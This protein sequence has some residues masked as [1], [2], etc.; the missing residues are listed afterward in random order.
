M[1]KEETE[2]KTW[3]DL[4]DEGVINQEQYER[5]QVEAVKDIK[6]FKE[7]LKMAEKINNREWIIQLKAQIEYIKWKNNLTQEDLK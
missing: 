4:L 1:E 6:Q 3:K 5:G 7:D 2:L